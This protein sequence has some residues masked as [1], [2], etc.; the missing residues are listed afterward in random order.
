M[1][2]VKS[3]TREANEVRISLGETLLTLRPLTDGCMRVRVTDGNAKESPS[4]VLTGI[5]PTPPF[6]MRERDEAIVVTTAGMRAEVSRGSGAL[7]FLDG[8]GRELLAEKP[9]GRVLKP[10]RDAR[11]DAAF[12]AE[13]TFLSPADER[14]YGSGQFQDGYLN[15]RDLPR[16]LT[17]VN[18]QI[19]IPFL[20]SS[21]GYGLLWHHYGLTEL[22]PADRRVELAP[23]DHRGPARMVEVT[24][25]EGTKQ[26]A[27]QES[28]FAGAFTVDEPGRYAFLFDAGRVMASRHY[29][30]INGRAVVDVSNY[31]LPPT[32]GGHVELAAGE[33]RVRV[34]GEVNDRPSLLVRRS[35]DETRL[36]AAVAEAIDYVVIAGFGDAAIATYRRLTGPAP[37]MPIWAYGYI[38]C[39]ERFKTQAELLENA[40]EFRRR[41]LPLDLIVQ[42]WE[43]WGKHG[44]NAMRFDEADYPDPA[45]M[46]RELHAMN[47]RLMLS[48]WSKI[49]PK[50]QLGRAFAER[51]YFIPGT[52]WV[53][54][55]NPDAAGFYWEQFSRRL[56]S[57]GIDA[58][59]QDAT[60][61]END[62]LAGRMT[63]AGPGERVRLV[64]PLL[65]TKTVYEGQRADAPGRR[66]CILTRSAFAGAQR[67][68]AAAWSGD[69]GNDWETLRRQIPAGLNFAASGLPYW[70]TDCG[71]FFRPGESQYTDPAYGERFL[72]WFQ[73]A[74]F[75]P[76]MRVH[77]YQTDTELWR[78]GAV[79]EAEARRYLGLRYRLL[80]YI[81]SEASRVTREGSTLMRPLAMDFPDDREALEQAYVY[82]FGPA[83]LVAPVL[84]PGAAKWD[85]YLPVHA[86]GW[87]DFWTGERL[88]GG[89]AVASA[90]PLDRIPLHARAGSIVPMGPARQHTAEGAADPIELR[91][92]VGADGAYT[93]YEDEGINYN[94]ERGAWAT[95]AFAWDE[96]AQTMTIGRRTGQFP[97]ML[98]RRTFRIVRVR[99]GHGIGSEPTE[100]PDAEVEYSGESVTV[101]IASPV[102]ETS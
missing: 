53:D 88:D 12:D 7:R 68:A 33:H 14:L 62:D 18:T 59:W 89:R 40:G 9:G 3:A 1:T 5:V 11:G 35:S 66:V 90:A 72:R 36:R 56:L 84:A 21:R 74:T 10:T 94:Y 29:I 22:N 6:E 17:Q 69:I 24:T 49:D 38:H 61:P 45:A 87:W 70:T 100:T 26:E 71:G 64:Y 20:L 75:C 81:Y 63:H 48:V 60:E 19:A 79:V 55:F 13:V 92:Y 98:D 30:E 91:V 25:T 8:S 37:L 96:R 102:S 85:V 34:L 76:L 73:F 77:G 23:G 31:W 52:P 58:W 27:R 46:V 67:Y 43:Y 57:L 80:P 39:R 44:W 28:D 78:F 65:V 82:L 101:R 15:A 42:D 51:G 86:G 32:T 50:S 2:V 47:M 93:L 41:G 99:P 54:F 95:I 83:L 16:R 4:L 97:G